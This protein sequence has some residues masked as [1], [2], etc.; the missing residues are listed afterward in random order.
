MKVVQKVSYTSGSNPIRKPKGFRSGLV[1]YVM[2][3]VKEKA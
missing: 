1:K 3:K 2:D